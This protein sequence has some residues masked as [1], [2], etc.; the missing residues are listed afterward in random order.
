MLKVDLKGLGFLNFIGSFSLASEV[1]IAVERGYPDP[2]RWLVALNHAAG[3]RAVLRG[4]PGADEP[5]GAGRVQPD[6]SGAAA[7]NLE[8]CRVIL[9]GAGL[10]EP[11]LKWTRKK[12]REKPQG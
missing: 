7:R 9:R 3:V 10:E 5:L 12:N 4:G 2:G 11:T 6:L 1:S 8:F